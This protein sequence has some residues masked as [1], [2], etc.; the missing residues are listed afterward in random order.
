MHR[1]KGY[2]VTYRR[3]YTGLKFVPMTFCNKISDQ[4]YSCHIIK[5]KSCVPVK[6][7]TSSCYTVPR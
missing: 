6:M 2:C 4:Q 3:E 7:N 1:D 5:T